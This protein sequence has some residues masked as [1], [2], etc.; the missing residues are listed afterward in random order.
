MLEPKLNKSYR[1]SKILMR[2]LEIWKYKIW[3][4]G[5]ILEEIK[6]SVIT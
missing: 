5:L 6:L 2:I 4:D 1:K 3:Q